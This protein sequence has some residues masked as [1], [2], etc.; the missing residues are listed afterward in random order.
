[1]D[2]DW[3][4]V[5][6]ELI[7]GIHSGWETGFR[8]RES[9]ERR[10]DLQ[11]WRHEQARQK[12]QTRDDVLVNRAQSGMRYANEQKRRT[13][14]ELRKRGEEEQLEKSLRSVFG[15]TPSGA[16]FA[17]DVG[18]SG[19]SLRSLMDRGLTDDILK[20][21][22]PEP[23]APKAPLRFSPEYFAGL[24][25]ELKLRNK[26]RVTGEDADDE[27]LSELLRSLPAIR[28]RQSN[29]DE[30]LDPMNKWLGLPEVA[31]KYTAPVDTAGYGALRDERKTLGGTEQ[32]ILK[33]ILGKIG[34]ATPRDTVRTPTPTAAATPRPAGPVPG[35]PDPT[36]FNFQPPLPPLSAGMKLKAKT[37]DMYARYLRDRGYTEDAWMR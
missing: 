29:I 19:G 10:Q 3:L 2:S 37:D 8:L 17:L 22:N 28:G 27:E 24:E 20:L 25:N 26:Y 4:S 1:M 23:A 30:E 35:F 14:E 31:R 34:Q 16:S 6:G 11:D 7:Q 12:Q 18:K 9:N 13:D 32:M 33:A 21:I 15:R 5:L 36:S